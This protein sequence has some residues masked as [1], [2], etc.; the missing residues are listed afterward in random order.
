MN[1]NCVYKLHI[2]TDLSKFSGKLC[3][4][5]ILCKIVIR[6]ILGQVKVVNL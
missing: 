5:M 1:N 4:A 6:V 3:K 2:L